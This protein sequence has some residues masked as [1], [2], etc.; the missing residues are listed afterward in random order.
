MTWTNISK[1]GGHQDQETE[2]VPE[3]GRIKERPMEQPNQQETQ[4]GQHVVEAGDNAADDDDD[5]IVNRGHVA[6]FCGVVGWTVV[7]GWCTVRSG[8]TVQPVCMRGHIFWP[9]SWSQSHRRHKNNINIL[10]SASALRRHDCTSGQQQQHT[11]TPYTPTS[12][13]LVGVSM[14]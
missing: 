1:L 11:V 6:A 13:S 9:A 5:E 12:P 3:T 8:T 7:S 2:D 10:A 4:L 14:C